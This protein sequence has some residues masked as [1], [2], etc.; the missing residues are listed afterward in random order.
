MDEEEKL[1]Q[2]KISTLKYILSL[3]QFETQFEKTQ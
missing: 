3:W 1:K 2:N